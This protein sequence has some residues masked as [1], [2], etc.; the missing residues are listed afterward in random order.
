VE[1]GGSANATT[2]SGG[3][4]DVLPGAVASGTTITG[5]GYE[6]VF[7]GGTASGTTLSSGTF[8]VA[9]GG[10]TGSG[11]VSF[12]GGGTFQLDDSLHF[13]GLVAGFLSATE[14]LD[15]ADIPYVPGS[16]RM[17]WSSSGG[18]NSGTLTVTEG[19]HSAS[20]TLLGQYATT[21]IFQLGPAPMAAVARSSP[22]HRLHQR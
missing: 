14:H 21:P 4:Q 17:N 22:T 5:S 7:S 18:A 2:L 10:A 1:A 3:F 11:A 13:G 12:A 20:L 6:Y 16:T 8:E 19:G 9:S 15:L